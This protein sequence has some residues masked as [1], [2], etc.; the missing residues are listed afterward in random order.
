[1]SSSGINVS[2]SLHLFRSSVKP[3]SQVIRYSALFFGILYGITH[4]ATLTTQARLN[5]ARREQEHQSSIVEKARE[6]FGK[7]GKKTEGSGGESSL[8]CCQEDFSENFN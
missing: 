8:F 4:Q 1:M 7:R 5:S 6:E 3:P 2:H